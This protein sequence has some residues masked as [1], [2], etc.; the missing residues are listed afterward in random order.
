MGD[1]S[2]EGLKYSDYR[3]RTFILKGV[4]VSIS[5]EKL[6]NYLRNKVI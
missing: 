1:I 2:G 5:G 6:K 3:I 4:I